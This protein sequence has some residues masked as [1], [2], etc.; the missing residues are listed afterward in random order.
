MASVDAATIEVT[1]NLDNGTD[2]TLRDALETVNSGNVSAGCIA[3]DGALGINDTVVF[4]AGV[5]GNT[6][7]LG[8]TELLITADVS[9][10]PSGQNTV[11]TAN[12]A[13]D[14]LLIDGS[15]RV[16]IDNLTITGGSATFIGAAGGG[17]RVQNYSSVN[18]INLSLI[19]I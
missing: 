7:T 8:G 16:G 18:L 5:A 13:S 2:C 6:I 3:T 15:A 19:H 4:G 10:N 11:L 9:I 12:N 17:I 14:V 1:S